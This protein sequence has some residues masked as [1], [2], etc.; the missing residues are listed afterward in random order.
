MEAKVTAEMGGKSEKM[1]YDDKQDTWYLSQSAEPAE[2]IGA[3]F[4]NHSCVI[5]L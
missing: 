4:F 2:R 3:T 1:T 5:I